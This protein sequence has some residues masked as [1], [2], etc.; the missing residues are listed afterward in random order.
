LQLRKTRN[1][2]LKKRVIK[3]LGIAFI[4][5]G[6]VFLF[7]SVQGITGFAIFDGVRKANDFALVALWFIISGAVLVLV[8][9]SESA[10]ELKIFEEERGRGKVRTRF[11]AIIGLSEI[12]SDTTL[13]VNENPPIDKYHINLP[14][15]RSLLK[16]GVLSKE[17]IDKIANKYGE[18][19][20][21]TTVRGYVDYFYNKFNPGKLT[22]SEK[23]ERR[24]FIAKELR[25]SRAAERVF[26]IIKP[27]YKTRTGRL[28]QL[29][30]S[31][32]GGMPNVYNPIRKG[33]AVYVHFTSSRNAA[34]IEQ[35]GVHKK[36]GDEQQALYFSDMGRAMQ[37]ID[38]I[39]HGKKA[40]PERVFG[41]QS[42]DVAIIFQ[43]I[44]V[45]DINKTSGEKSI[46]K[47]IFRDGVKKDTMYSY[48]QI[49]I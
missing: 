27:D 13:Q 36:E 16:E 19:F 17:D 9:N 43:T 25:L 29:K 12:S 23:Q 32:D 41:A 38:D 37:Y 46:L 11:P 18:K 22:E 2:M 3:S 35:E 45:P 47:A 31:S 28:I 1:K 34:S 14:Q 15:L 24:D 5:I 40:P 21:E 42:S 26:D 48:N 33:N 6:V 49:K 10:L 39:K 20:R 44:E 30:N 7:F 8:Q 4:I